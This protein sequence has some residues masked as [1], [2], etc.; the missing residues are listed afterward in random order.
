MRKLA[1][2]LT[3]GPGADAALTVRVETFERSELDEGAFD[4]GVAA[5]SFHW[6]DQQPALAKAARALRAKSTASK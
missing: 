5:T 1:A 2:F 3:E 4:L 6:L